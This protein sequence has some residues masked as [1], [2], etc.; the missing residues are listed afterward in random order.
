MET[1]SEMYID[2]EYVLNIENGLANLNNQLP[3]DNKYEPSHNTGFMMIEINNNTVDEMDHF[4]EKPDS[5]LQT[6]DKDY[7]FV[8]KNKDEV[9]KN[10]KIEEQ[11]TIER[12][13]KLN[14]PKVSSD[15]PVVQ[16]APTQINN[17][18]V[19]VESVVQDA[20]T[21]IDNPPAEVETVVQ[22]APTQIDN[23]PAEVESVVQEASTQINN[24]PAEVVPDVSKEKKEP[25]K[26]TPKNIEKKQGTKRKKSKKGGRKTK[27]RKRTKRKKK[28]KRRKKKTKKKK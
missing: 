10:H 25:K 14:I 17:P 3:P 24:P 18:P 2:G 9:E 26:Q 7:V 8:K 27:K 22:D 4:T 16:D 19:E 11:K 5:S 1:A 20:P 28:K 21:Q 12:F 23:T 6:I 13:K 15:Q